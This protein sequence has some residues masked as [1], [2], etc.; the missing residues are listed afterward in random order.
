MRAHLEQVLQQRPDPLLEL[1]VERVESGAQLDA[2]GPVIGVGHRA[3]TGRAAKR[4]GARPVPMPMVGTV[5]TGSD[6]AIGPACATGPVLHAHISASAG[7][8][9]PGRAEPTSEPRT[10][11]QPNTCF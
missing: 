6:C 10:A 2:A 9:N 11:Y 4:G 1:Q 8:K 7:S 3:V 5:R